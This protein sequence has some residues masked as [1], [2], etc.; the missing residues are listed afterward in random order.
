MTF[1]A[2]VKI[3]KSIHIV[4]IPPN[5]GMF[6]IDLEGIKCFVP[7]CISG[8]FE[9]SQR[10]VFK[11]TMKNT[12]VIDTHRLYF[13]SFLVHSFLDKSFCDCGYIHDASI[14]QHRSIDTMRQKISGYP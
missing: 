2:V 10:S 13:A 6:A 12:G 5:G 1:I 14:Q 4:Q 9:K 3:F 8:S 11:M 7:P